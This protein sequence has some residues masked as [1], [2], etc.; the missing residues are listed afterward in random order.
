MAAR[1]REAPEGG[2]GKDDRANPAWEEEGSTRG[3]GGTR[4][5]AGACLGAPMYE[6]HRSGQLS[7][8]V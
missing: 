3:S 4:K 1:G 5:G 6:A 8:S 2:L 7:G